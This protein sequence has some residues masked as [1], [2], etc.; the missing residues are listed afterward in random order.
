MGSDKF[1]WSSRRRGEKG[2]RA[3]SGRKRIKAPSG[4]GRSEG[5][6]GR[7]TKGSEEKR[8]KKTRKKQRNFG[9]F[10]NP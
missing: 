9:D 3:R 6:I 10:R 7:R 8:G 5:A 2:V 1:G 4:S